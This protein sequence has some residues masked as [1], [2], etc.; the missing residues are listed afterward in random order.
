MIAINFL[1]DRTAITVNAIFIEVVAKMD[2]RIQV[3]RVGNLAID[4]EPAKRIV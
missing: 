3:S 4:V 1:T 2:H